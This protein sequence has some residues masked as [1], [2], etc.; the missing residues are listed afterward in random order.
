MIDRD[1]SMGVCPKCAF[2]F[3]IYCKAAFHGV[4][5]CRS[6]ATGNAFVF[7][8]FFMDRRKSYVAAGPSERLG[9]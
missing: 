3:C 9:L 4:A 1:A 8:F 7:F 5:P 6:V 2:A